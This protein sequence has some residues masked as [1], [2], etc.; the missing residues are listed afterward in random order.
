M[1]GGFCEVV[2]LQLKVAPLLTREGELEVAL[3]PRLLGRGWA[4]S[5]KERSKSMAK[6]S[7][8]CVVQM[9]RCVCDCGLGLGG[10]WGEMGGWL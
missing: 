5:E 10:G 1:K 2:W 7:T 3:V 4:T 9:V 8:W 6:D